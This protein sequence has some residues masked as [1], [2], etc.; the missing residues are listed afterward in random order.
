MYKYLYIYI[1]I[2]IYEYIYIY[3]HIH[4]CTYIYITQFTGDIYNTVAGAVSLITIQL[5]DLN[6]NDLRIGGSYVSVAV[7]KVAGR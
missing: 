4:T 7:I 6:N 3:I 5:R 1:Y 2:Y